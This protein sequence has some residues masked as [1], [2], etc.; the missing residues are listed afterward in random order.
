MSVSEYSHVSQY[1]STRYIT[2]GPEM[3]GRLQKELTQPRPLPLAA[4]YNHMEL[5]QA[6]RPA[7]LIKILLRTGHLINEKCTFVE[8]LT[9]LACTFRKEAHHHPHVSSS[10]VSY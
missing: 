4:F 1:S 3:I 10:R 7:R 2:I 8:A 5:S 6:A 9:W